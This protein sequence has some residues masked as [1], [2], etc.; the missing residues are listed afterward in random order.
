MTY[1]LNTAKKACINIYSKQ[2]INRRIQRAMINDKKDE[3]M[4]WFKK[5]CTINITLLWIMVL[6]VFDAP[7]RNVNILKSLIFGYKKQAYPPTHF[8]VK[9]PSGGEIYLGESLSS[10]TPVIV[11]HDA[12]GNRIWSTSNDSWR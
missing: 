11:I 3:D 4:K 10:D 8:R 2:M 12:Q 1:S 7:G 6:F 9:G 5:F